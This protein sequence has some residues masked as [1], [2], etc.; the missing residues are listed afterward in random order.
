MT[1]FLVKLVACILTRLNKVVRF[2]TSSPALM[3]LERF[4]GWPPVAIKHLLYLTSVPS[5]RVAVFSVGSSFTTWKYV[6]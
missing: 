3:T 1:L 4:L 5:L 2:K 6:L